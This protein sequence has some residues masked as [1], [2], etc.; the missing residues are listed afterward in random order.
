[1]SLLLDSGAE[2]DLADAEG[3]TPLMTASEQGHDVKRGSESIASLILADRRGIEIAI[4]EA[5]VM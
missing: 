4:W 5:T 2:V 3:W 1:M